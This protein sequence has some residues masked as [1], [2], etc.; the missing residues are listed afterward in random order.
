MK[1]QKKAAVENAA[2]TMLAR[3]QPIFRAQQVA[4]AV[5]QETGLNVRRTE[6]GKI[7]RKDLRIGYRLAKTV[8]VQSNSERCLVLRQ[9]YALK[10]LR[11]LETGRQIINVDESWLNNTRFLRRIWTPATSHG[12]V[13][14]K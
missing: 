12:T 5:K 9:Q 8:P 3:N 14:D 7:F 10:I 11:L 4:D 1:G 6:V 2:T 13:T